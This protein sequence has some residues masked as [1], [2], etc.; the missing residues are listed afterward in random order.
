MWKAAAISANVVS[1]NRL[2]GR[3]IG[4][5]GVNQDIRIHKRFID[6]SPP[7]SHVYNVLHALYV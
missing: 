5:V 1:C 3:D 6:V 2:L 7:F 4:I